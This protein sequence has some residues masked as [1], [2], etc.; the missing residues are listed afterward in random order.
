MIFTQSPHSMYFVCRVKH[1]QEE[2]FELDAVVAWG[3]V[4]L[5][6]HGGYVGW[7]FRTSEDC[8]TTVLD[9][10]SPVDRFS[11]ETRKKCIAAVHTGKDKYMGLVWLRFLD[12]KRNSCRCAWCGVRRSTA[13]NAALRCNRIQLPGDRESFVISKSLANSVKAIS[14]VCAGQKPDWKIYKVHFQRI[15][16]EVGDWLVV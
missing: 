1:C 12:G 5:G 6:K 4:E 3:P 13:S 8:G 15:K 10:L 11:W 14:V 9:K 2:D 7:H 16:P